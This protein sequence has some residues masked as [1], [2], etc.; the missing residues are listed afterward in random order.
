MFLLATVYAVLR[1]TESFEV[2]VPERRVLAV[3][4]QPV[5][6]GCGYTPEPSGSLDGLIVTWQRAEDDQVVHSFYFGQNQLALQSP[7]YKNRTT[8]Y[9]TLLRAGNSSL[10]LDR[11]GPRD[12]G[13]YLCSV[14]GLQGIGKAE[15]HLEYAAFYAEPR[16]DILVLP[17]SVR[18]QFKSEGYPAPQVQWT[19]ST[20]Q[21]LVSQE[22][23]SGPREDGLIYLR[24]NVTLE[25]CGPGVN[26]NFTLRNTAL[27]Q[28]LQRPISCS[29]R[30]LERSTG[31]GRVV[32]GVVIPLLIALLACL[33]WAGF[34]YFRRKKNRESRTQMNSLQTP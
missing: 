22:K 6:L 24:T 31:S 30:V 17:S 26:L 2:T 20:G 28:V 21:D 27:G 3:L 13:R 1:F 12:S 19:H 7:N 11:V 34:V 32:I 4:G 25:D 5:V 9:P 14:S 16:L 33:G 29:L 23:L 10:R 18:L 8:V 15:V